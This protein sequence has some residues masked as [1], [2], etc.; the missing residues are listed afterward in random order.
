MSYN[1][2]NTLCTY[3]EDNFRIFIKNNLNYFIISRYTY[4]S[5]NKN[6]YN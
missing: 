3:F 5:Y 6:I 2:N 4:L 1:I